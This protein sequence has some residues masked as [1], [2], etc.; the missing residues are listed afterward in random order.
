MTRTDALKAVIASLEAE[1]AALKAFDIDALA[2]ATVEKDGRIGAL[3]ARND[4]PL[5]TEERALAEQAK[6]LNETARVYVNL[7]SANVKQR[8]EALTGQKPVAYAPVRAV[9]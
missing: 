3:A 7:M 6:Q 9:A 5:S 4:N 8:L 2:A 1:L